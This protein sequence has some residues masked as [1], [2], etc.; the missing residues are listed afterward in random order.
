VGSFFKNGH[1]KF[2][3]GS[4][5][6]LHPFDGDGMITA[7]SINNGSILFRNKFVRT[8]GFVRERQAKKVLYRNSFGTEKSGGFLA[9][10]FDFNIKNVANTNV[11]YRAGRLLALWEGGLP[12]L[13]EPDSLRTSGE[14]TFKGLLKKGYA[15]SAHPREDPIS[16]NLINFCVKERGDKSKICVYEFD[17]KLQV[18]N[19]V[20][21]EIPGFVFCHDFAITENYYVFTEAPL[22]FDPVPFIFGLKPASNCISFDKS[23]YCVIHLV[24]RN[25]DK[26]ITVPV[27]NHFN[28]HYANAYE[29]G[30]EVVID[31]AWADN[32]VLGET[33]DKTKHIW[34]YVDYE[35]EVPFHTITRLTLKKSSDN[36]WS[37]SKRRL[38]NYYSD[39]ISVNPIKVGRKVSF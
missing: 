35:K 30:N 9:N 34:E 23:K 3:I 1:A 21:F 18:K 13:V 15:F 32:L 25:G 20:Q 10:M 22:K 38:T 8:T 6:F 28:F 14:Y 29:E 33:P 37:H 31:V 19:E 17:D 7:M 36:V 39:F 5:K 12:Y 27:Q 11:I 26:V 4:E 24:P 2:E 16:G